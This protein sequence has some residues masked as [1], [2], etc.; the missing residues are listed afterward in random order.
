MAVPRLA[1]L[2]APVS[3]SEFRREYLDKKAVHI[4]GD[5]DKFSNLFCWDSFN[6]ILNGSPAP[7]PSIRIFKNGN[8]QARDAVDVIRHASDGATVIIQDGDQYD[9]E[10]GFF[11]DELSDEIGERTRTNI[12]ASYVGHQGFPLHYDTHDFFIIQAE[13]YKKWRVFPATSPAPLFFQKVHDLEPPGEDQLYLEC[14]LRKGDVLYVPCGHWHEALAER[15]PSLHLTLAVFR[16]N[17]V[18]FLTWFADEMRE[19]LEL[20][21]PFPLLFKE[22]TGFAGD[23]PPDYRTHYDLVRAEVRAILE[24]EQ[25]LLD[26]FHSFNVAHQRNRRPFAFP[27]HLQRD[28]SERWLDTS[29]S[30]RP[31]PHKLV[32]DGDTVELIFAGKGR[33]RF[34]S[35]AL[36]ALRFVFSSATFSGS[37][38]RGHCSELSER[39]LREL[40]EVLAKEG[41]I[42]PRS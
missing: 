39:D 6:R 38:I 29:F 4:S 14:V 10:L 34:R 9:D 23:L 37:E 28:W 5:G 20:R 22:G 1:S 17:G 26:L 24:S 33:I 27:H 35:A 18:D 8:R 2:L 42:I 21:Q 19:R 12:Y 30:R 15:E 32:V 25:S 3:L 11:L 16:R 41:L 13:G 31:Y 7:H 36:P 40:L